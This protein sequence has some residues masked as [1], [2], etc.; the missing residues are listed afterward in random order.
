MSDYIDDQVA[1]VVDSW[2]EAATWPHDPR[3]AFRTCRQQVDWCSLRAA[4]LQAWTL[5]REQPDRYRQMGDRA[6]ERMRG[7]CSRQA[8]IARLEPFLSQVIQREHSSAL[9]GTGA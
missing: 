9:E 4:Y 5:Y 6:I 2:A 1:F 7:Y 8:V 3:N